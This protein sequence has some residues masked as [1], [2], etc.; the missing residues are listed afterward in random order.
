VNVSINPT[1]E[2]PGSVIVWDELCWRPVAAVAAALPQ[3]RSGGGM[4]SRHGH[5][6]PPSHST[7][8]ITRN[9]HLAVDGLRSKVGT[10]SVLETAKK[11]Q[12]PFQ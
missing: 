3:A 4:S 2:V 10:R 5:R 1:V 9:P 7:V 6:H 11:G 8:T 12:K